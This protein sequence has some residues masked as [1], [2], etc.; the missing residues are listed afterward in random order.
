[1][2]DDKLKA[3]RNT[4]APGLT[5]AEFEL[6]CETCKATG[7]NP[8]TKEIWAIKAG[9]RL[10]IMSGFNGFLKIA[11]SHPQYDGMEVDITV[12]KD[13][14]P[15]VAQARVYRKDRKFPSVGVALMSEFRGNTPIWQKMPSVMLSKVAKSHAIR[16]A[17]SI[18]LAGLYTPEEMPPTFDV[19]RLVESKIPKTLDSDEGLEEGNDE[20]MNDTAV[21]V[22]D[23]SML[24]EEKREAAKEYLLKNEAQPAEEN[25][26][27]F[28]ASKPLKKAA[29]FLKEV[30]NGS[31]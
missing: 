5:D 6:F 3:L 17:F 19:P 31:N 26:F 22:Y 29:N 18:E 21:Y 28:Y 4:I 10:Q 11:N 25:E 24:A 8:I 27:L 12:D 23:L 1:M 16:E 2:K 9:G 15:L 13:N 30:V 14:K 7:L 20:W